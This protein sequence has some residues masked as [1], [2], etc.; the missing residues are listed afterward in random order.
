[1]TI[2]KKSLIL[3]N[4]RIISKSVLSI[5]LSGPTTAVAVF[6][7]P[8]TIPFCLTNDLLLTVLFSWL[9]VHLPSTSESVLNCLKKLCTLRH[10]ACD[11]GTW[12]SE[13]Q[14]VSPNISRYINVSMKRSRA[15]SRVEIG[16]DVA[17]ETSE[18]F[19]ILTRLSARESFIEFCH[20]D[21]FRTCTYKSLFVQVIHSICVICGKNL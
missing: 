1:V 5:Y 14:S 21:S 19:H 7:N 20:R 13:D 6:R 4:N 15:D 11:K 10:F 9:L 3:L 12:F 17:P 8:N 2:I 18:N 16:I